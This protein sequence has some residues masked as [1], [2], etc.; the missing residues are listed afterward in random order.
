MIPP[1]ILHGAESSPEETARWLVLLRLRQRRLVALKRHEL[2]LVEDC[3]QSVAIDGCPPIHCLRDDTAL[4]TACNDLDPAVEDSSGAL[5]LAPLD[6][7]VYDRRVTRWLWAFD[8]TWEAYLP[9][10]KRHRGHYALPVLAGPVLVGHV[11]PKADRET[12]RLRVI[13]R[14]IRRGHLVAPA[15]RQLAQFLGLRP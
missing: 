14:S 11:D 8:Y 1:A 13:S 2:P 12:R 15:L 3:V 9:A 4:L 7:L 6:P 10:T 5:L